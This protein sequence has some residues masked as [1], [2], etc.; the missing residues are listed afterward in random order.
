MAYQ[1]TEINERASRDP[2]DFV[3]DCDDAYN[4]KLHRAADRIQEHAA[5]SPVVLL[6]GPSGS[7]KTTTALKL[8]EILRQTGVS[9]HAV[10][11]D[12]YF[13]SVLPGQ[14]PQTADGAYDFESPDCLDMELLSQHFDAL[15]HGNPIEIPN[16]SFQTQRQERHTGNIL[17]VRP[18]DLVIFEGIHALNDTFSAIAP[19]ALRLYISARSVVEDDAGETVFKG[20][21]M[22]L[23]RR[24][25]RD[26]QF[27]NTGPEETMKMWANVRRGEKHYISPYKN[28]ADILFDSSLPCEVSVLRPFAEPLFQSVP[29]GSERYAELR[30]ILPALNAFVPIDQSLVPKNSLLREFI[31][32]GIY[33]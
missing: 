8:E 15:K 1:L 29:E 25:V 26:H 30:S 18:G 5:I 27:R 28:K 32:G 17:R 2:L 23:C 10:A 24:L 7:G 22:R 33:G 9:T 12:N 20:T 14:Y 31:G 6:S 4:K 19:D 13:R 11:L 16:Y 21:W 3:L